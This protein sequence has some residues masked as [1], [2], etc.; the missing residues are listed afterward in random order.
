MPRVFDVADDLAQG[1]H[2]ADIQ[3]TRGMGQG[4][5]T[6]FDDDSHGFPSAKG[7]FVLLYTFAHWK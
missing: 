7:N 6:D 3:M 2:P 5:C 4:G 1:S